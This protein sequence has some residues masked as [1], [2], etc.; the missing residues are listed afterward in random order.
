MRMLSI[1]IWTLACLLT[2][3]SSDAPPAYDIAGYQMDA[4]K[5]M[6]AL[7]A[8]LSEI[9]GLTYRD[10]LFYTVQDE[11]GR[12]YMIHS[13]SGALVDDEKFWDKGDFEGIEMINGLCVAMKS[14]G[15]LYRFDPSDADEETTDRFKFDFPDKSNFE[16]L[17]YDPATRELLM[18]AKRNP[19][20]REK[21]IYA[22]SAT[23]DEEPAGPV[24]V[25][26][27]G[28]LLKRLFGGKKKGWA[29]FKQNVA[30]ASYSFNPS[31]IAV[32]PQTGQRFILSSPV[33]QLLVMSSDWKVEELIFLDNILF[34]QPEAICFDESGAMYIANEGRGGRANIL[35][36]ERK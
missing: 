12:V 1:I 2:S 23:L 18:T 27:Q 14:N 3:C 34:R 7:N 24:A 21:E 33:P 36:F 11:R 25:L 9:S 17:G 29:R 30:A 20:D 8:E 16:G 26:D 10:S 13:Q 19:S 31:A 6:I 32:H 28:E 5:R 35:K 22:V 4:P 15:N